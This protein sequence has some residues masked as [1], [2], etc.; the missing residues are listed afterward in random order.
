MN[1]IE[2]V[3]KRLE[4]LYPHNSIEIIHRL[5]GGMSNYTYV[6]KIDDEKYTYRIIGENANKFV[7]RGIEGKNIKLIE[8]LNVSNDT[9]Y[10][11][12][13][14]GDK[15]AKYL[16]GTPL[17][18]SEEFPYE[19]V[20]D[21]LKQIHESNLKAE[22]DYEP[23]NRL[24]KYENYIIELGFKHP[25][26]Y[27]YIKH[28]F[29][30]FKEYLMSQKKVLCHGDS[31]PS[32]FV[33]NGKELFVVDFE[34]A[35]NNDLIYDI[36]CFANIKNEH[37]LELLH[38]YYDNVDNDKLK[39]FYLWRTFQCFQ[40]YNVAI[41]KELKGMSEKLKIDFKLVADNYLRK[42]FVLMSE[43]EKIS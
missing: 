7:D 10:F 18:Q 37:G 15:V 13:D 43:V 30:N 3:K 23:F 9:V 31:Q 22:N 26:E 20:A 6:V 1:N 27:H 34:F 4:A 32:N 40:W 2:N 28:E 17:H 24:K 8:S 41:Y 36:A 39:R 14:T 35:G 12:S 38:T 16:E 25:K 19:D 42:I 11:S 33:Y 5:I 21:I 29:F